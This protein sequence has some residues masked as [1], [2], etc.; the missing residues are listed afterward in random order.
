MK[1][2]GTATAVYGSSQ[3]LELMNEGWEP[4]STQVV[5]G[6]T[7]MLTRQIEAQVWVFFKREKI[8][9]ELVQR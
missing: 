5:P 8:E 1:K 7:N 3:H 2:W 4:F 9:N 6:E